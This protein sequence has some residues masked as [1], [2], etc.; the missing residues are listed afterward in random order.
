M[1]NTIVVKATLLCYNPNNAH[2]TM[3]E[4]HSH[5]RDVRPAAK[6]GFSSSAQHNSPCRTESGGVVGARATND[7]LNNVCL[8]I[9]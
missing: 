3:S 1:Q 6:V 4:I 8:V 9:S 5:V 7:R 2:C